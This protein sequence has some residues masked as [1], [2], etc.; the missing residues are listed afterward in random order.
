MG[1]ELSPEYWRTRAKETRTLADEM[2]PI[3]ARIALIR[4]A[5]DYERIAK[6]AEAMQKARRIIAPIP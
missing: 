6:V 5:E 3:E 1:A 4:N 2:L